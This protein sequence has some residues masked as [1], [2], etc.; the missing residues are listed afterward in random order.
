[1]LAAYAAIGDLDTPLTQFAQ[2]RAA[3]SFAMTYNN[4]VIFLKKYAVDVAADASLSTRLTA[5]S[6]RL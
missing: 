5:F 1:V 3:G 2:T 6:P 4:P